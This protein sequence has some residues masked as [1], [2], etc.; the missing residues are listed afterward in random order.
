M[1]AECQTW[2]FPDFPPAIGFLAQE[3]LFRTVDL[4]LA[5]SF[6]QGYRVVFSWFAFSNRRAFG[7][8]ACAATTARFGS[9]SVPAGQR[10]IFWPIPVFQIQSE[11]QKGRLR[12]VD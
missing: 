6:L 2:K 10:K 9:A 1:Q 8:A 3:T 5:L 7:Q 12:H 11:I 4:P